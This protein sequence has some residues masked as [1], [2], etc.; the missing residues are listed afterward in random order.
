VACFETS[1]NGPGFSISLGNLSGIHRNT[2]V[3]TANL[4]SLL[5]SP[6][7][8]PSW[9]KNGYAPVGETTK[10]S[11]TGSQKSQSGA[12]A[13]AGPQLSRS[14]FEKPLRSACQKALEAEPI[15]TKYDLQ[16]GDG[17]CGEAVAGFCSA[18]LA[19]LD[20]GA[21]FTS[22]GGVNLLPA[23]DEIGACLEDVGGSLGA[24]LSILL[25]AFNNALRTHY[26]GSGSSGPQSLTTEAVSASLGE[27]M[28]NLQLYTSAR[29]GDRT[30]MDTL[31]PFAERLKATNDLKDAVHAAETGA[32]KT[33]KMQ[34]K[35]GR[36]SYVGDRAPTGDMPPDPGAYAAAVFLRALLDGM[37]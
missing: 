3:S 27:A 32:Q 24:I 34:P 10:S 17:D 1:L 37:S 8:A 28:A 22:D 23:L 33:A 12:A 14:A 19:K 20:K 11:T 35:F 7:N 16:M 4:L 15:I 6:T 30:V 5:D 29:T 18:I 21:L 36:A 26:C 25:T 9:P 2:D 31:I 13:Y